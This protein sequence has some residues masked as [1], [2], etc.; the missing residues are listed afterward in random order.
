MDIG[1]FACV[2][3]DALSAVRRAA[4]YAVHVHVKDF[5]IKSGATVAPSG[6]K[7]FSSRGGRYIRGTTAGDGAI[8][9]PQCLE[10]LRKAGYDGWVSYEFEGAEDT[11]TALKNGLHYI[12][13]CL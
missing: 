13:D 8:P 9:I 5:L 1:N 12:Q 10:I 7:W 4:P 2:D 6:S 11:L 3:E